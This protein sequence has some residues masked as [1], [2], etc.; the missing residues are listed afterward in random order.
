M[1]EFTDTAVAA[2]TLRFWRSVLGATG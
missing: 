2:R 1:E